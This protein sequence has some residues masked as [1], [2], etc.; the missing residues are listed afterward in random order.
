MLRIII[1]GI[2]VWVF[3]KVMYDVMSTMEVMVSPEICC[4]QYT[5][6]GFSIK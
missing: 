4:E 6:W 5:G 1:M 3:F 2:A